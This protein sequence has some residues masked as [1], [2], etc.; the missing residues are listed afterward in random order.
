[1][2]AWFITQTEGSTVMLENELDRFMD[3]E[4]AKEHRQETVGA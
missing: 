4:D 3:A 2:I 1:V